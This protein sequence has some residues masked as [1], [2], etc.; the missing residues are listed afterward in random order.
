MKLGNKGFISYL[1]GNIFGKIFLGLAL[2]ALGG[3]VIYVLTNRHVIKKLVK[4]ER[5]M[6]R[7]KP[8]QKF[9]KI[10]VKNAKK[11]A[12]RQDKCYVDFMRLMIREG[13]L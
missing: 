11:N 8:A 9:M 7:S 4:C 1:L 10:C 12:A 6:S 5:K 13:L 3:Y 2:A